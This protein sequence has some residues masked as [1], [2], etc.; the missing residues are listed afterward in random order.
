MAHEQ[1]P[2]AQ[3]ATEHTHRY[4][5]F[6]NMPEIGV[7]WRQGWCFGADALAAA[8]NAI[9]TLAE[10]EHVSGAKYLLPG[11]VHVTHCGSCSCLPPE[12]R[13]W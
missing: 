3:G 8:N 2:A 6:V 4:W 12:M 1:T 7:R 10:R 9:R 11:D 13:H 5:Y